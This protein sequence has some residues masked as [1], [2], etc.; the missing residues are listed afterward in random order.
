M[1]SKTDEY[2]ARTEEYEFLRAS[3]P[4]SD[5]RANENVFEW[6]LRFFYLYVV[7]YIFVCLSV[8]VCSLT[9][10]CH[11]RFRASVSVHVRLQLIYLF[12]TPLGYS[13]GH[14]YDESCCCRYYADMRKV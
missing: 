13:C 7:K 4:A 6:T 12:L 3:V 8:C 11:F 1:M 5:R 10:C 14:T 9:Q 2:R